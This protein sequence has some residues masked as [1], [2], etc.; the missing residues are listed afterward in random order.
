M[1]SLG[2]F[3]RTLLKVAANNNSNNDM[4]MMVVITTISLARQYLISVQNTGTSECM[5]SLLTHPSPLFTALW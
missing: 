1:Q 2:H 5:L 3:F 4:M